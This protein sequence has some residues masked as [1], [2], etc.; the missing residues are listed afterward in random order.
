MLELKEFLNEPK[1][2]KT[3]LYQR[4]QCSKNEALILK[5]LCKSYVCA[6]A[7]VSA[8]SLLV[9]LFGEKDYAYLDYLEDLKGLIKRGFVT[10]GSGFFKNIDSN[11][12]SNSKLVLL[13]SELSLSQYFL[14]F[15]DSKT[16]FKVPKIKAYGAYLEYLRDEFLKVELYEK[17]SF[18]RHS[19]Y[20]AVLKSH[21]KEFEKYIKECL[22]LSKFHN[23]LNAIFKEHALNAKEQI[24]FLAL[25]KEEYTL[26]HENSAAREQNALLNLI[27]ENEL[28]L[29]QNKKLLEDDSKLLN[30]IE[31]DEYLNAFGELSK[32]FFISDEV[33]E[34]VINSPTKQNQKLKL[35]SLVK[36]QEIFELIEPNIDIND[37]IMPENTKELLSNILKQK[38]KKVLERLSLWGIKSSKNIE[39]KIIFYGP[40]GTGKTMSAFGVAK[41]M[42]KAVLSFD[43]S[44]IL[45]K[46]VGESEQNVRK[47]FDTYKNIANS[48]KQSPIL[49]LN[50]ADQFLS[51][52]IEGGSG[53]DKM[54]NQMQ[55]IFLEQIERFSGVLIATTNFLESLDSAF[56]RRFDL[57][58]EF[59]KPDFKDRL[60]M[61]EKFLPQNADFEEAFELETLAKYELSGAQILM[62]VK[63]TALK[64]AISKDGIFTMRAFLESIQKELEGSFDKSK[65]V[66]F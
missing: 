3:K 30:L 14:D 27:S 58:I 35:E 2:E 52:R 39:A 47:I 17:L 8:F 57:K 38:D 6:S 19:E 43:C 49:L 62:V 21:I 33:L 42:K 29:R 63:N 66:G 64:T 55:N 50:E 48:C 7:S 32:S 1:I 34:R 31:Y 60:K 11:K 46:W 26:S 16:S 20:Y 51:T 15:I 40:P 22:K 4:L 36:E 56:S 61:W 10:S 18:A 28:E 5:E 65:I 44:K 12:L 59:K 24:L 41:A 53:S 37:I 9:G 25:L 13:Q 45:S 54:H 23:V